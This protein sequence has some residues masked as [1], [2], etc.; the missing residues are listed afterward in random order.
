[1]QFS[2]QDLD[3]QDD[4]DPVAEAEVYIGYGRDLQ[5]EDILKEAL[6]QDPDSLPLRLKLLEIH[7]LRRDLPAFEALAR[8]IFETTGEDH[9][10]WWRTQR[11]GAE[12]EPDHPLY[13]PGAR[14]AADPSARPGLAWTEPAQAAGLDLDLGDEAAPA[15]AAPQ[16]ESL[17]RKLELAG[18]F[19]AIGDREGAAELA[20]EV[21]REG[22][23]G[24]QARAREL[25]DRLGADR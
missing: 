6:R 12:L 7:A 22:D 16:A 4:V 18:E 21:L 14:P 3:A 19:L 2:L 11:L 9:E 20:E 17:D 1:M 23:P 10:A 13:Q 24:Q 5:A 8:D 15:L 25:L